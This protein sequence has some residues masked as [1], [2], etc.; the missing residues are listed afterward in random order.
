[1]SLARKLVLQKKKSP[2][3]KQFLTSHRD[4]WAPKKNV[5]IHLNSQRGKKSNYSSL[6][7]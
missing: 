1:M 3:S 4:I 7:L 6:E 2:Q 5:Y